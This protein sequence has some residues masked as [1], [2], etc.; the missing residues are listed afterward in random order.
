MSFG[1]RKTGSNSKNSVPEGGKQ[2]GVS[3]SVFLHSNSPS[4]F[5]F[6]DRQVGS[7]SKLVDAGGNTHDTSH[8]GRRR[9]PSGS[10]A[11]T[12][13]EEA[14]G[15]LHETA[16][17]VRQDETG[18]LPASLKTSGFNPTPAADTSH[19]D[20]NGRSEK[21]QTR[22]DQHA[23][24]TDTLRAHAREGYAVAASRNTG[25]TGAGAARST[26]YRGRGG[27]ANTRVV[28]GKGEDTHYYNLV[29]GYK[30]TVDGYVPLSPPTPSP[31]QQ[32]EGIEINAQGARS[33]GD[34]LT[35]F[36]QNADDEINTK[37]A[38]SS[39][40]PSPA[41]IDQEAIR[42]KS[43]KAPAKSTVRNNTQSPSGERKAAQA[44]QSAPAEGGRPG[45]EQSK[46]KDPTTMVRGRNAKEPQSAPARG[47]K[48]GKTPKATNRSKSEDEKSV[49]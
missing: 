32:N 28:H 45:K 7:S 37:G 17:A 27:R 48:P 24:R 36:Q 4:K 11:A 38:R 44:P 21:A 13:R 33:G 5:S 26:T 29:R 39:G 18:E 47:S 9:Q 41:I 10:P 49:G 34:D 40:N 19:L 22:A 30:W 2:F 46:P 15:S 3:S 31:P 23:A 25:D 8:E 12:R 14:P 1:M 35:T 42:E 16:H 20:P 43:R 6:N